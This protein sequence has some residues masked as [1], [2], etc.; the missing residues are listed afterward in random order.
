MPGLAIT[1]PSGICLGKIQMRPGR[2]SQR[3]IVEAVVIRQSNC[4]WP[5]GVQVTVFFDA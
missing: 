2:K 1:H 4:H 5:G 3:H